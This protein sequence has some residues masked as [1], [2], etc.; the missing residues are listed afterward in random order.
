MRAIWTAA[1][2]GRPILLP[3]GRT[4]TGSSD[5]VGMAG[6]QQRQAAETG[7]SPPQMG[8]YA[9]FDDRVLGESNVCLRMIDGAMQAAALMARPCAVH[10]ELGDGRDVA[11]LQQIARH[12]VLP[13]I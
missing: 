10:D 6:A 7:S 1:P 4:S 11:Q 3:Q 2:S 12:E 5:R 9:P 8:Q 13:V